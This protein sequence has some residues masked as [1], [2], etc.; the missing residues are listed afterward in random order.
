MKV[1]ILLP[2]LSSLHSAVGAPSTAGAVSHGRIHQARQ[3]AGLNAAMQQH[4]K[5]FGTFSDGKYLDDAPY[6]E[7][8]GQT[9]Q[10]EM[11]TPGNSM[12]WDYTEVYQNRTIIIFWS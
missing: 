9:N 6:T 1:S 7:I 3:E 11:Y 2:A 5:Y 8:L 10:F 12:K 4:G